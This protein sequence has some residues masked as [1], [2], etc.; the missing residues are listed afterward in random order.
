MSSPPAKEQEIAFQPASGPIAT[1]ANGQRNFGQYFLI[2]ILV[3]I[4]VVFYQMIDMFIVPVVLAAVFA[5]LF[6][7]L[8]K[9]LLKRLKG[10]QGLSAI[11]CCVLLLA[12]LL[13]PAFIVADLVAGEAAHFYNT[14]ESQSNELIETYSP[15]VYEKI[16]QYEW[17]RSLEIGQFDWLAAVQDSA[18][19]IGKILGSVINKTSK[20]TLQFFTTL[21]ITF[22]TMFYFFRDGDRLVERLKYLSPL[23]DRYEKVLFDQFF[24]ISR[25][26]IKGTLLIGLVQ[27]T[28]GGLTLWIFDFSSPIL[29]GVVMTLLS[30][31]PMVGS[32]LVMYPAAIFSL[33]TGNIFTGIAIFLISI[34]IISSV[35][36]V[37]RPWL[38]GRDSGM[39][40]LMIFFSTL[41]GISL[42]GVMGF[43]LGP[44]IAALFLAIL[45]LYSTEIKTQQKK[46]QQPSASLETASQDTVRAP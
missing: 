46:E 23:N 35:D 5:G 14:V 18:K 12:G 37:L 29:W 4:A 16:L 34:L 41:G 36:N 43:I 38:V 20:G 19:A 39:H 45:D 1:A 6:Y 27:G 9:W 31:I 42:F 28:L 22:F 7:P 44:I 26:T 15:I 13:I 11:I 8:Y 40:D 21:F 17:L 30:V 25:A 33:I 10:R 32:W 2:L 24:S 3:G